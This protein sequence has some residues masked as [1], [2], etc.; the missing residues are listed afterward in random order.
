MQNLLS[1]DDAAKVL[2]LSVSILN[3]HRVYGT[4]PR[5]L[6]LGRSV[7]YSPEDLAEW[8]ESHRRRSTSE[9]AK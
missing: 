4:G 8:I 1:V 2:G 6:K 7:R 3:K 9:Q 5:F